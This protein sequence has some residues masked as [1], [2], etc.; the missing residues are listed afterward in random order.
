MSTTGPV[1]CLQVGD[2]YAFTAIRDTTSGDIEILILW[3]Y[4]GDIP[5]VDR[6]RLSMWVAML[7]DALGSCTNVSVVHDENDAYALTV[8]LGG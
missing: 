4:P 8:Q 2:D 1:T 6:M 7:R 5:V 3:Y